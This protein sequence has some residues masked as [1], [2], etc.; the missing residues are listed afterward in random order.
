VV[1]FKKNR[2]KDMVVDLDHSPMIDM[3]DGEKIG[4]VSGCRSVSRGWNHAL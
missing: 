4:K 3:T 2:P 1:I